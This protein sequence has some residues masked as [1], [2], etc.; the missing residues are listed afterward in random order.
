MRTQLALL[1]I[2]ALSLPVHADE[3][4][5]KGDPKAAEVIVTKVCAAC[6]GHDGNSIQPDKPSLAGQ[7][8]EYLLKQLTNFK[9]GDRKNVIMTGVVE[10]LNADDIKNLA[11][12]FSEQV[13]KPGTSRDMEK[14]LMGQKIFRGG[15]QGSGVPACASCHGATAMGIPVKFPRL[16]GQ[17]TQYVLNQLNNFRSGQRSNDAAKMMRVIAS[18]MTPQ[19]MEAVAQYVQ[20]IR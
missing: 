1:F 15:V 6:H 13:K 9:S 14:A 11:T 16:A 10:K 5:A 19:E 4:D 3:T 8:Y 17:Q 2:A 20:G 12:Y 18:R 7:G